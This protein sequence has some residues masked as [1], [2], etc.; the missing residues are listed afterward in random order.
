VTERET[1]WGWDLDAHPD[2]FADGDTREGRDPITEPIPMA[3][4][5][6][7]VD[8]ADFSVDEADVSEPAAPADDARE[9]SYSRPF[10]ERPPGSPVSALT[11]KPAPRPWY[12]TKQARIALVAAAAVA[13]LLAIL[14]LLLRSPAPS[15]E[16]TTGP[17]PSSPSS[18]VPT[19]SGVA[20][21]LTSAPAPPPLPPP[22][23]PPPAPPPP[24]P[25]QDDAPV[26]TRQY[27]APRSAPQKPEIG[28][29]RPPMSVAPE[30]RTPPTN[31]ADIGNGV[32]NGGYF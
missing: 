15:P 26:Y 18:A 4:A 7:S 1:L 10:I 29:T 32:D 11:F 6:P 2:E 12:R 22:P 3:E 16:D 14:P 20:P 8:E 21:T 30:V 24:P 9:F 28:V 27:P 17:A 5:D 25:A 19:P 13:L 31:K 23:P